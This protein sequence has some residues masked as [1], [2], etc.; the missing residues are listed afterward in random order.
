MAVTSLV[1][2]L[3]DYFITLEDE[4][5]YIWSQ[6]PCFS[7]FMF[8]WIRYYT[9]F[10]VSF[11]VLQIHGFAIPGVVTRELCIAADPTTRMA[12]A[13]SLWS[14]EIFMM[15]RIY[16]LFNR[17]TKVAIFNAILFIVSIGLFLW[18]MIANAIQRKLVL[19]AL[20]HLP[21]RGCPAI[22][23]GTQWAL[24]MPAMA[25][26]FVLFGFAV[27]KAI[28][29]SSTFV[30]LNERSSLTAVLLRENI[31]YFAII[32]CLLIFNNIMVVGKSGIPWF[33]FGPFHASMGI[34]TG[35][36][37]IHLRKFSVKHLEGQMSTPSS[38]ILFVGS[39]VAH[40]GKQQV[41]VITPGRHQESGDSEESDEEEER[42][43][44][45]M[46]VLVNDIENNIPGPSKL[47]DSLDRLVT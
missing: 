39:P 34:V 25:F 41:G 16:V 26:E 3:H 15:M 35:R 36:M 6:K 7:K 1:W 17:S 18:I 30:Q 9:I 38:P 21:A 23:G 22:N 46:R 28:T 12:G 10:L 37:I 29:S 8:F 27:L 4:V 5:K 47:P 14:I 33:G 2:V 42:V 43:V 45:E 40:K 19:D 11:D 24:W 32:G 20:D 44:K 31:A 13:I